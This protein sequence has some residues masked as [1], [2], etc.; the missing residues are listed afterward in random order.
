VY[1]FLIHLYALAVKAAAFT[2]NTKARRL[3]EGQKEIWIQLK[4]KLIA[5]ERRIWIH[6]ASVGEFEQGRPLIEELRKKYPQFKIAVSF[7]SPSGYELRKNYADADDVFYLPFDTQKNA[8]R[9]IE[10]LLPEKVFFI[11][12]EFWRNYLREIRRR[13]IPL[14]LISANFRKEQPFFKWY[15]G[16]YRKL[17]ENFAH[18][19]VQNERSRELLNRYGFNNVTV[20]GDTRF[21]RVCKIADE[22][23]NLPLVERFVR[24]Q[25][26]LVAGSTWQPDTNLLL[27]YIRNGKHRLKWIIAPHEPH[28]DRI[29]QLIADISACKAMKAIRFS[30]AEN[31]VPDEYEALIIDNIGMLASLYRYG[32]VAY[33]GGGFG[34]GI[35]NILEAAAYKIPVFFGPNHKKFQEA[36]DLSALGGAFPVGE[37]G[38][39]VRLLD[40]LL[41]DPEKLL[42]SGKLAGSFVNSGRGATDKILQ[43][44]MTE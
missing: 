26:C 25:R 28:N 35:H 30:E 36:T 21:D 11:K 1:S 33:I 10:L 29:T 3:A 15:G 20:T 16:W 32:T 14:Y 6:C 43:L 12:Y 24:D 2:G 41:D 18:F 8:R 42:S 31:A 34:K 4:T 23:K 39:F 5:D 44:T 17:L 37:A 27:H 19:F 40:E 7:F 9:F 22:A 38:E 13:N